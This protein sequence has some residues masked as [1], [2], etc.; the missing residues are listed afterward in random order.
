[1]SSPA[2][3]RSSNVLYRIER[4][5]STIH[6]L[7]ASEFVAGMK[8]GMVPM[9]CDMCSIRQY[10]F[11]PPS[12]RAPR[13]MIAETWELKTRLRVLQRLACENG[14]SR[15][16]VSV[17]ITGLTVYPSSRHVIARE[18]QPSRLRP[19]ILRRLFKTQLAGVERAFSDINAHL[20][21]SLRCIFS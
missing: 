1:M 13:D 9:T 3:L 15:L 6:K 4:E 12:L 5:T 20:C 21:K 17:V 10:V 14:A 8:A 7:M 19:Q 2:L 16:S 11:F 18:E